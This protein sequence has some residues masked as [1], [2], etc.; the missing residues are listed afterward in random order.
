MNM[1]K[2]KSKKSSSGSRKNPNPK[3]LGLKIAAGQEVNIGQILITQRGTKFIPGENVKKG[4]D[5]TLYALKAGVLKFK[6]IRKKNFDNTQRIA[7]IVEII[8]KN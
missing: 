6:T 2:T 5:D 4:R 8:A 1:A 7:K 3:Y